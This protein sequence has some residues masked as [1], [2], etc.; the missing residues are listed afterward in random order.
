MMKGKRRPSLN[1]LAIRDLLD[2]EFFTEAVLVSL[3]ST[4]VKTIK[5]EAVLGKG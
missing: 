1:N 5:E 4:A 2:N 3:G